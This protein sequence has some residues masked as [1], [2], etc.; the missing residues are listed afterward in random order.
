MHAVIG[1]VSIEAGREAEAAEHLRTNILPRVK[2]APGVVTGHWVA[3]QEGHGMAITIFD[4][5]EAA[6]QG[7]EMAQDAPR[8]DFVTFDSIEVRE[9]IEHI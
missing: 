5:E 8:P 6:Q 4:S 3:P 7:A 2:E 9:V 1:K